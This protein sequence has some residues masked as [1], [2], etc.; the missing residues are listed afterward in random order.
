VCV[1]SGAARGIDA[2]AHLGALSAG[3]PTVAVLGCGIDM[4]YPKE[5][6]RLLDRIAHQ[7]ALV[8]EYPPGVRA[9]PFRFPARNRIVAALARAVVVVEGAIG[10]GSMIT[11]EHA[12][13]LGLDVYAVPGAVSSPLAQVPLKLIREG[14][15]MIRGADDLIEDLSWLTTG[16]GVGPFDPHHP[17]AG[18]PA[19]P[20]LPPDGATVLGALGASLTLDQ[21]TV[22]TAMPVPAVLAALARLELRQAVREVGGRYERR[23]RASP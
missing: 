9:D 17:E 21:L 18:R 8:S 16:G 7:G 6:G 20:A 1:V 12:L 19:G 14:A 5:H 13:D 23:G 4:V 10:S 2:A 11:A 22:L 15:R 3:G